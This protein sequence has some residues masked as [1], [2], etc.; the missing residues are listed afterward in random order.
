MIPTLHLQTYAEHVAAATEFAEVGQFVRGYSL[1]QG[2]I[3]RAR[4]ELRRGEPWARILLDR[5][6]QAADAYCAAYGV[7]IDVPVEQ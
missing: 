5:Y 4:E 3:R 2:G 1:L 7:R 6:R